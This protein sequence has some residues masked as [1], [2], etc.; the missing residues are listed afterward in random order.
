MFSRIFH[1]DIF[2]GVLVILVFLR[3]F[4]SFR[5]ILVVLWLFWG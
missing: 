5:V 4:G 3:Y 1:F 2:G